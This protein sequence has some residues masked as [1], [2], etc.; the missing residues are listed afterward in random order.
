MGIDKLNEKQI[1]RGFHGPHDLLNVELLDSVS[2][3][4]D[5]AKQI[6]REHPDRL[7][8]I[9]TNK[10][11]AGRGRSGKSFYSE[12][13]YGLYFTLAFFPNDNRLESVPLY[14][15]LAATA[16]VEGLE[17][18]VE[19]PLAVKWV[20]DIFYQ[21]KKVSGILSEMVSGTDNTEVP[22]IVVGIGINFA[23]DFTAT[24]QAVQNVAGTLF[25]HEIPEKF[26]QNQFL[27]EFLDRF[28]TYHM[29]FQEKKFM[30]IYESKLMGLGKQVLYTLNGKKKHGIIKGINEHGHLLVQQPDQSLE[31]LYGQEVHFGS[32][33]FTQLIREDE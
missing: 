10:Q 12:L 23:G 1:I 30:P 3:T 4:N 17:K 14:T 6:L 15:I 5:V 2:S 9:A 24:D 20:N 16:L 19:Q 13:Q 8:V 22:G 26:S 11:T 25:E 28:F 7:S 29:Q 18:Y 32:Q 31:T 21:G 27:S 33:Q